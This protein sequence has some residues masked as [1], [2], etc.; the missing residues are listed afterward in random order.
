[1][2]SLSNYL[3][4]AI[5]NHVF[6][7]S[8]V[9][10]QYSPPAHL[11]CALFTQLDTATSGDANL[12]TEVPILYGYNRSLIPNTKDSWT[13]ASNGSLTNS[14]AISFSAA[15][16]GNWGTVKGIGLYDA[17]TGGNLL[18]W[19]TGVNKLIEDTDSVSINIGS[20]SIAL[21]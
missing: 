11:Y 20:M 12:V 8:G 10:Q 9:A 21:D 4:N 6:G 3:E 7:G 1:M 2:G 13:T 5:L 14:I 15:A 19:S 16:G 18:A 17:I